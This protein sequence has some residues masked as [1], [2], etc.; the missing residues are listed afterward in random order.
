LRHSYLNEVYRVTHDLATVARL[1][2]HKPG[3]PITARY[4]AGANEDVDAAA[5]EAFSAALARRRQV[6]ADTLS[7]PLKLSEPVS[8]VLSRVK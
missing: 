7:C 2:L 3:S 5:Q 4:A 6:A 1:A 8:G